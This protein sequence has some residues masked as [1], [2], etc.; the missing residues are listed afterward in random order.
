MIIKQLFIQYHRVIPLLLPP[1]LPI[2]PP[3][4]RKQVVKARH[5]L[6]ALSMKKRSG[7]EEKHSSKNVK[8]SSD[9]K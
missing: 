8:I 2:F 4:Q 5:I 9:T 3:I 7:R 6:S 1:P